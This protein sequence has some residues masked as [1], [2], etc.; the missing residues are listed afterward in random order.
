M[1]RVLFCGILLA[2]D[3][4]SGLLTVLVLAHCD[5]TS[6]KT[7]LREGKIYFAH[8]FRGFV[9]HVGKGM[10]EHSCLIHGSQEAEQ[11]NNRKG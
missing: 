9:H 1:R 4:Y 2:G 8:G 6:K 10:V 11:S 5:H 3:P 7:N